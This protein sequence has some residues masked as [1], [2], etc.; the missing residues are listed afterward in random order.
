MEYDNFSDD[1]IP[2]QVTKYFLPRQRKKPLSQSGNYVVQGAFYIK[3]C[4]ILR[5]CGDMSFRAHTLCMLP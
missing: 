2:P 3:I 5:S 1:H 4:G